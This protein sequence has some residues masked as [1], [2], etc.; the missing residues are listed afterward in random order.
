MKFQKL[1]NSCFRNAG[2]IKRI[3]NIIFKLLVCFTNINI[4]INILLSILLLI[5]TNRPIIK[6]IINSS[7]QFFGI[8]PFLKW[9]YGS[10]LKLWMGIARISELS[11]SQFMLKLSGL[12]GF[13][14]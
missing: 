12:F 6:K 14:P 5:N 1:P 4:K 9:E 7:D 11:I 3:I 8:P 10:S 2:I 13:N